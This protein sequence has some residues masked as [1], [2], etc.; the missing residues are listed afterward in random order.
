MRRGEG[1]CY[2]FGCLEYVPVFVDDLLDR[3]WCLLKVVVNG[4]RL[5]WLFALSRRRLA[6][7]A[8]AAF[9][10][11]FEVLARGYPLWWKRFSKIVIALVASVG[12]EQI[13][14]ALRNCPYGMLCTCLGGGRKGSEGR[15]SGQ[16]VCCIGWWKGIH[17]G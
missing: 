9:S 15:R 3:G 1:G 8:A 12:V 17:L 16:W 7:S 4:V 10:F 2:V 5:L 14:L 13:F 6:L 11:R